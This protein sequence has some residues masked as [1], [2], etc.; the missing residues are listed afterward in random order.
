MDQLSCMCVPVCERLRLCVPVCV[1]VRLCVPVYVFFYRIPDRQIDLDSTV[2]SLGLLGLADGGKRER[3][4]GCKTALHQTDTSAF[5][6]SGPWPNVSYFFCFS[7]PP[8]IIL[9]VRPLETL[10]E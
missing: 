2:S 6:E 9:D 8:N 10:S 4:D 5:V 3:Q 7:T 1:R